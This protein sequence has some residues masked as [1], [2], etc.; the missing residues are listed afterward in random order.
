MKKLLYLFAMLATVVLVGCNREKSVDSLPEDVQDFV[1]EFEDWFDKDDMVS[2]DEVVVKGQDIIF[3]CTFEEGK[4][5]AGTK[6]TKFVKERGKD[7]IA[8]EI[9]RDILRHCS[10]DGIEALR[11]GKYNIILHL[12]GSKSE[13]EEEIKISYKKWPEKSDK[14]ERFVEEYIKALEQGDEEKID[15][16]IEQYNRDTASY[17]LS[18]EQKKRIEEAAWKVYYSKYD[19]PAVE[20]VAAEPVE[21]YDYYNYDYDYYY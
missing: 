7:D 6:V 12:T 2:V 5:G 20:E 18:A 13:K 9:Q 14:T 10:P 3:K 16:L 4:K 19:E 15:I 11:D 1:E 17:H 8:E 21:D